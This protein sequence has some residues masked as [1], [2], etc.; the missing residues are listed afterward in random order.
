MNVINLLPKLGEKNLLYSLLTW[1]H[2]ASDYMVGTWLTAGSMCHILTQTGRG[3]KPAQSSHQPNPKWAARAT[4]SA[5][6]CCSSLVEETQLSA[7]PC[8]LLPLSFVPWPHP[9]LIRTCR[10]IS[11]LTCVTLSPPGSVR[12]G[13]NWIGLNSTLG[14]AQRIFKQVNPSKCFPSQL[15]LCL[16]FS[17]LKLPNSGMLILSKGHSP[18]K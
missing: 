6:N 10:L 17:P 4:G 2:M 18:P 12:V 7:P 11:P 8:R 3:T 5:K 15:K 13:R 1:E 9:Q 16:L 14:L